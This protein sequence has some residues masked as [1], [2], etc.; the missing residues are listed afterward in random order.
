[1]AAA[2]F[3]LGYAKPEASP[4]AQTLKAFSDATNVTYANSGTAATQTL[5][6]SSP[7]GATRLRVDCPA[8]NTWTEVQLHSGVSVARWPDGETIAFRIW[9]DDWQQ[10][11]DIHLFAGTSG[12]GA[13][14][15]RNVTVQSSNVNNRNGPITF[16]LNSHITNVNSFG[17]GTDTLA[18]LKIRVFP[19]SGAACRFWVDSYSIAPKSM[20]CVLL[21]FDDAGASW[22][23][24]VAP[25][26]L[27]NNM[28]ASFGVGV[29][30][31][32]TNDTL[33][34]TPAELVALENAGHDIQ[35]HNVTN[36]NLASAGLTAY[37][38]EYD[39]SAATLRS[40]GIRNPFIYHPFVQGR[41]DQTALDA[42]AARGVKVMRG[43]DSN[44]STTCRLNQPSAGTYS[45]NIVNL[46]I[47]DHGAAL[48]LAN[49]TTN[50][51]RLLKYGGTYC[52]MFHD[53][54]PSGATGIE[55]NASDFTGFIDLLARY[56]AQGLLDVK[57]VSDWYR[58]LTQPV[59]SL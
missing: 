17:Y 22:V 42:L 6:A 30:Q 26:L 31:V 9:F 8:G 7:F 4:N 21:T 24:T 45:D 20:P 41:Y 52:A 53:I 33:Y 19:K 32:G 12:Y 29:G 40:Y 3:S 57:K 58:G 55:T 56:R 37:M 35:V 48:G 44:S 5:D 47:G 46:K 36:T 34:C 18:N 23:D 50:I 54:V 16:D 51:A 59:A 28:K 39:A 27:T 38:A 10:I 2:A 43:V 13:Y 14:V 49:A 15:Q 1:M 11:S 25:Y